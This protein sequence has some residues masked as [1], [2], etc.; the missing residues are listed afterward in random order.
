MS[1][2]LVR[3]P[4]RSLSRAIPVLAVIL[5]AELRP[6]SLISTACRLRSMVDS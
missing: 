1:D 4:C 5:N 6:I 3:R 2:K